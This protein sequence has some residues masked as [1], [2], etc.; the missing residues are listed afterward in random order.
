MRL[1][2]PKKLRGDGRHLYCYKCKRTV[3]SDWDKDE[4]GKY[5][6]QDG[7]CRHDKI[8]FYSIPYSKVHK[9]RVVRKSWPNISDPEIFYNSHNE[10]HKKQKAQNYGMVERV[11][12]VKPFLLLD[13]I[14][15]YLDFLNNEP[16]IVT[17]DKVKKRTS[18]HIGTVAK[19]L[20]TFID[21]LR[22][23]EVNPSA[24]HVNIPDEYVGYYFQHLEDKEYA[25]KTFNHYMSSVRVFYNVMMNKGIVRSNPFK[26]VTSK[27]VFHDPTIISMEEFNSLIKATTFENR[28]GWK[29]SQRRNYYRPWLVDSWLL[30]LFTGERRDG[31]FRLK[32]EH[33]VG[34][35]VKIPNFKVND[36]MKVD[37][38]HWALI[39]SD[40]AKFLS[41]LG[42]RESDQYL[43][44]TG[45]M[46]I[47]TAKEF[48]TEAFTHFWGLS[49]NESK[50][51]FS[52]LRKT[53]KT[54][55]VVLMGDKRKYLQS[56][57]V[58]VERD[59]YIGQREIQE[60]FKKHVM[61]PELDF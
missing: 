46:N 26:E 47:N 22:K 14:N 57:S 1:K 3:T 27:Y 13:C 43:I 59:H 24:V 8:V 61:F 29:G 60:E 4:N 18:K 17:I 9:K 36:I 20:Q 58:N 37:K 48:C 15:Y 49:S 19:H 33:I 32:G 44:D 51:T 16:S 21:S 56:G 52:N 53:Q 55:E 31:I 34:N 23:N 7:R 40:F 42:Y 2:L 28:W 10:W 30:G 25:N 39:T 38:Y 6:K 50:K 54:R 11:E 45:E 5:L 12:K 35:Y 41:K